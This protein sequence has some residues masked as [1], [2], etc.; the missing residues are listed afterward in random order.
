MPS[1]KKSVIRL[2]CV[3]PT[4]WVV[5]EWKWSIPTMS[6]S[7]YMEGAIGVTPDRPILIDRF[8]DARHRG[9]GR[10]GLR[11]HRLLC[12]QLSCSTSSWP[13]SIRETPPACCRRFPISKEIQAT[14]EEYTKK[15]ALSLDVCGLM[16][17]QYAIADGEV[18]VLEANP[19]ASRTV[20]LVSKVCGIN[21]VQGGN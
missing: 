8:S 17:M 7:F 6:C 16:N 15:I 9:G 21:M 3:L 10:C 18:Y 20:P 14:I 11:R 2:W 12:P 13:A 19:R 1:P 4:Y 5:G